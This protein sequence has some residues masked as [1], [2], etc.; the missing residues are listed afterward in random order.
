MPFRRFQFGSVFQEQREGQEGRGL[1]IQSGASCHGVCGNYGLHLGQRKTCQEM[2]AR[3]RSCSLAWVNYEVGDLRKQIWLFLIR[4]ELTFL[5][6][7]KF[8]ITKLLNKSCVSIKGCKTME[9]NQ[10][11]ARFSLPRTSCGLGVAFSL[12]SNLSSL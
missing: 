3:V 9:D 6:R 7:A 11:K 10:D 4:G 2:A 5:P 1:P 8:L 12:C